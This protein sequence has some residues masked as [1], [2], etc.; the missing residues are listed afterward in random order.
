MGRRFIQTAPLLSFGFV[1][2]S[3]QP[4]SFDITKKKRDLLAWSPSHLFNLHYIHIRTSSAMLPSSY[5]YGQPNQQQSS[6]S[7][8]VPGALPSSSSSF[9]TLA[10]FPG[11]PPRQ[12]VRSYPPLNDPE[13]GGPS[14][15]RELSEIS[16]RGGRG[17]GG[18]GE[19]NKTAKGAGRKKGE[20]VSLACYSC[21]SRKVKVSSIVFLPF[22]C[23]G[24]AVAELATPSASEEDELSRFV[25][26]G[27][28]TRSRGTE[29]A[30]S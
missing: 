23:F 19:E 11:S 3:P 29:A 28:R 30:T 10:S 5:S 17:A 2:V 16:G 9:P 20:Q 24:R 26:R 12:P 15:T 21:R 13:R 25:G 22:R 27:P 1:P 8:S 6:S 18:P 4:T 7:S 14:R